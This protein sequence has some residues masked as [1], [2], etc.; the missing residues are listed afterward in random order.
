MPTNAYPNG[1][2]PSDW[3]TSYSDPAYA[4]ADQQA[5]SAVGLPPGLLTAVR[6][7]GEKSN[8]DQVSSANAATP[9]QVTPATRQAVLDQT[10][11]DA[12]ASPQAAA[13]AAAYV[14]KQNMGRYGGDP[15]QA[16]AAYNGGTDPDKWGSGVMA[17][18]KRVTGFT[19]KSYTHGETPNPFGAQGGAQTAVQSAPNLYGGA[20]S[21]AAGIQ[22]VPNL[23]TPDQQQNSPLIQAFNA[24]QSGKMSPQDRAQFEQ[25][26]ANGNIALPPG[27]SVN[28]PA[29][30]PQAQQTPVAPQGAV[31]AFNSGSMPA[32]EAAQFQKDVQAG[33]VTLPP[34]ANL[35]GPPPSTAGREAG[36]T[37][38][39]AI[40]GL[41]STLGIAYDPIAATI[42]TVG[43]AFGH[44]PQIQPLGA[45]ASQLA[46]RMGLPA[47][48]TSAERI[49]QA[50]VQGGAE[51]A[52][53]PAG[54][55][56]EALRV[57]PSMIA[58]GA[59]G[60]AVGEYVHQTSGSPMLG[61]AA[62]LL[63]TAL[64]PV[65]AARVMSALAKEMPAAAGAGATATAGHVEPTMQASTLETPAA[66]GVPA[67]AG[68]PSAEATAAPA[69]AV[70]VPEASAEQAQT[71]GMMARAQES[72]VR[73]T[74]A[75]E[76]AMPQ[77]RHMG[78]PEAT[79]A[80][81]VVPEAPE[82]VSSGESAAENAPA[83]AV[84]PAASP[85]ASASQEFL[86]ADQLAAQTRAAVGA[87]RA[88][89]GLGKST[90]QQVLAEQ[91]AP[92]PETLAAAQRLGVADNLQADHLTANQ[93]Y[94]ELAQAIKSTPGSLA[95]A[96]EMEGLKQVAQRGQQ[97]VTDAGGMQDLSELSSQVKSEL[98]NTQQQLDQKAEGLYSDL[99]NS[100]PAKMGVAPDNV[101]GF[102]AQ[103]ADEL[104]GA[105][106]LSPVERMIQ[107]KLAPQKVP[108]MMG[109][110]E[111]DPA[112]LGLKPE[113]KNPTYALLDDVR[114]NIGAG[115]KNQGPFKDADTGLLKALY[116]R[117]S[118]DQRAA[119]ANV[120]GALEKFDAARATVQMRKSVE[121]DLTSLYGKQLGDSLVGK[122]GT[123]IAV[124]PKGDASKFV[125]LIKSVPV[126]MRQQVTA[127]GLAY[128]F[129]KATRNG[130]L[131]FKSFA[132]WMD[133]LKKNSGAFNAVM[134]NLPAEARQQLLDLAKVSR[135]ISNATRETIT[136]GRIMAA[137]EELNTRADGLMSKIMNTARQAAVG[138]FGSAAAAGAASV[139][140]PIGAGLSHAVMSALSK[141]KP[142]VMKAADALIVSPEFQQ[143]TRGTPEMQAA[144]VKT[145][146]STPKFRTFFNLARAA[147][148]ANDPASREH[149]LRAALAAS[150]SSQT[151]ISANENR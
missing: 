76:T 7:K 85:L 19:P 3:P 11:V 146:A 36:L 114:K 115:L 133:G 143:M 117:I 50:G 20:Q 149:W 30:Q 73:A 101:L 107:S 13:Y 79:P 34:G 33:A 102:I 59:G 72:P 23:Y 21:G 89:F 55:T 66:E 26:V 126:S 91:G 90:A 8:A 24:Y 134:G 12:Y 84:N 75:D 70:A 77:G 2:D 52:A 119:L 94:R 147:T 17:Y 53:F 54:A 136:T 129:G 108:M 57:L 128:A 106:N 127:S 43:G 93:A 29:Q 141:G 10:G 112:T 88:P 100:V 151:N 38:R 31:D 124:L 9:Y 39:S 132:D 122:L 96:D 6:T 130:D 74:A 105:K 81:A 67:T 118:E 18:A 68:A 86:P 48:T 116:G 92:D 41:G 64:S 58:A 4:A 15:V 139:A 16:V 27:M 78:A 142:D 37:A 69:A 47:P 82:A 131:N 35:S 138:K 140:G 25:D 65:A 22:G 63:T 1:Y 98:M 51:M 137:R 71:G 61:A 97:I 62:N 28:A 60:G 104:G 14:L 99:R 46:D 120:A 144:A 121:D 42:N 83:G 95:R 111:V 123:A 103:R 87:G 49:A 45:Q 56:A 32:A 113:V 80:P 150:I 40:Q 110:Q 44:D 125:S 109:G 145:L 135:G 148:A 5:S